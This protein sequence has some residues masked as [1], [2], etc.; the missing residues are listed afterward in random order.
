[1]SI[2]VLLLDFY[3]LGLLLY[4][5]LNLPSCS[6]VY[7]KHIFLVQMYNIHVKSFQLAVVTGSPTEKAVSL[8]LNMSAET[9]HE[10]VHLFVLSSSPGIIGHMLGHEV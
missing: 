7:N 4:R 10:S 1:M 8:I 2:C 3:N 5:H 9:V 6:T